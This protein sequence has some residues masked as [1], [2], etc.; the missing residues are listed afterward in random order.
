MRFQHLPPKSYGR[1]YM[2]FSLG[3]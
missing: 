2:S 3:S 1:D